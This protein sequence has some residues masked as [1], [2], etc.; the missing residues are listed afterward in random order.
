MKDKHLESYEHPKTIF[1]SVSKGKQTSLN[2]LYSQ[3]I[4][5]Y[6]T[7]LQTHHKMKTS[8]NPVQ[9]ERIHRTESNA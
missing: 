8:R 3:L 6:F 4:T 5:M 9:N 2:S 7:W 1:K